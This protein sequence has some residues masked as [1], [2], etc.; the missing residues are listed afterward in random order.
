MQNINSLI[1]EQNLELEMKL[2]LFASHVP[3]E[4]EELDQTVETE[5]LRQDIETQQNEQIENLTFENQ[6]LI[7]LMK[8]EQEKQEL[9]SLEMT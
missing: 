1:Q 6:K 9:T 7:N 5:S 8:K 4:N 2:K 3:V